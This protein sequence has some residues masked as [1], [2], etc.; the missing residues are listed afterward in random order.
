MGA[1]FFPVSPTGVAKVRFDLKTCAAELLHRPLAKATV[2]T[3][4][5]EQVRA[6][7]ERL[8]LL[9]VEASCA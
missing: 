6:N 2:E 5:N 9:A 8:L 7:G 4:R 3:T 1:R